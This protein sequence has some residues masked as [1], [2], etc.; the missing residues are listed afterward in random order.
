MTLKLER[1]NEQSA[2]VNIKGQPAR[3]FSR[4]WNTVMT[5]LEFAL[6][7][8][9]VATLK[10]ATIA[11]GATANRVYVQ[12]TAPAS[13]VDGDLW[14]DNSTSPVRYKVRSGGAWVDAATLATGALA[15]RDNVLLGSHVRNAA[16][17]VVL[18]DAEVITNQGTAAAI[19]GQGALATLSSVDG[20]RL[21]AAVATNDLTDTQFRLPNVTWPVA[22]SFNGTGLTLTNSVSSVNAL[23]VLRRAG[24]GTPTGSQF[25]ITQSASISTVRA[26][27]GDRIEA[28]VFVGD[29]TSI[30]Q[31]ILYAEFISTSGTYISAVEVGRQTGI[32]GSFAANT[33]Q[34]IAGIVTA[35]ANAAYCYFTLAVNTNGANPGLSMA[36]PLMRRATA[37]QTE[38]SPYV[39]GYEGQ[40]GA[41]ITSANTAAAIT[42]QGP[43]ATTATTITAVMS[44]NPN[45][46]Q[47][48]NFSQGTP[49]N[50]LAFW[51]AAAG[52]A[53]YEHPTRGAYAYRAL[54]GVVGL[55]SEIL[56]AQ[57]EGLAGATY[58][59]SGARFLFGLTAGKAYARIQ[60]YNSS[61]ALIGT[62]ELPLTS[63]NNSGAE[64]PFTLTATAP[65]GTLWIRVALGV[66]TADGAAGYAEINWG[67]LKL[68]QGSVA[69]APNEA[70]VDRNNWGAKTGLN[71]FRPNDTILTNPQ[72]ETSL[73]TAAGFTGQGALATLNDVPGARLAAGVGRNAL[74]DTRF[75]LPNITW[76]SLFN[77]TGLT[78]V[79]TTA[80]VGM[81]R[82]L[83][84][85][86][87]GSPASGT[88]FNGGQAN[89]IMYLR[90]A[91]GDRV[92]AHTLLGDLNNA[93]VSVGVDWFNNSGAYL[94][95]STTGSSNNGAPSFSAGTATRVGGFATAPA[96]AAFATLSISGVCNGGANPGWTIAAPF[97]GMAA[98]GQ[99]ELSP[100]TPGYEG[101]PG[102]D[103]TGSN[104]AAAVT[105][106]GPWATKS[107]TN[108][109]DVGTVTAGVLQNPSGSSQIDL[110]NGRIVL[111]AGG[112][113]KAEGAG[114]GASSNLIEWFG[115][116]SIA[117]GSMTIA[118]ALWCQATDGKTY[119]R[120]RALGSVETYSLFAA[121][122]TITGPWN[123]VQVFLDQS[124]TLPVAARVTTTFFSNCVMAST[125]DIE[126]FLTWNYRNGG[127]GETPLLKGSSS[128]GGTLSQDPNPN[129]ANP[130][131]VR[132]VRYKDGASA[133]PVSGQV[134]VDLPAGTH[135]F[136][137]AAWGAAANHQIKDISCTIDVLY[138]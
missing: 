124:I 116:D 66:E 39:P 88:Q 101:Q 40:P 112:Y 102:A 8:L 78:P 34:R 36:A 109:Q 33:Q 32:T 31:A 84:R 67:R 107:V 13:P 16:G 96:N 82:T 2:L 83:R 75:A 53:T 42:G 11:S 25:N 9:E 56:S 97:F 76:N 114:F 45:L 65:T 125:S 136:R 15:M 111:T 69:T 62:S 121:G 26:S 127:G 48:G 10:L 133:K 92:E 98:A 58:T 54:T 47:N 126:V 21:A 105:G 59:L 57:V 118:N 128:P 51:T 73:G 138:S 131:T 89:P 113:R 87:T 80:T 5:R 94:S 68:E 120:G 115:P 64:Q 44:P 134:V 30:S 6:N 41:D 81:L 77:N 90:V 38:F 108:A 60:F 123:N 74:V 95:T 49:N 106:Q 135:R 55:N 18:G 93:T 91:P 50:R 99:T 117:I 28:S 70:A 35:P 72:V 22:G 86:V 1:L 27:A 4:V 110:T 14:V 137:L 3:W 17:T 29:A 104:T 122:G 43:W 23:R 79:W 100:Y 71:T 52:W 103:I 85:S 129:S 119:Y 61:L 24:T 37:G 132:V 130:L 12:A 7:T 19:T 46:L 63:A 20:S